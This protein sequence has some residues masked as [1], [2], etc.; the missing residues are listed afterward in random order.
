MLHLVLAVILTLFLVL[1]A[2]SL[3]V[4]L[5]YRRALAEKRRFIGLI[6]RRAVQSGHGISA[7]AI[8]RQRRFG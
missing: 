5:R 7:P 8:G 6:A 2:R 1:Q 3:L 4:V